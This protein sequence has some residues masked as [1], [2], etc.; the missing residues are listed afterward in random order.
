MSM[1]LDVV[2]ILDKLFIPQALII[3]RDYKAD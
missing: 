2:A 3:H 1:Y